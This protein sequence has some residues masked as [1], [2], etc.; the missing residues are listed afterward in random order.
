MLPEA[1]S[2]DACSLV[3]YQDRLAVTVELE[4]RGPKVVKSTFYRSLIRS[5]ERLDYDRVD[6]IFAGREQRRRAVGARRSPPR[7]RAPA[8]LGSAREQQAIALDTAEPEFRFDARG[9]ITHVHA[10]R[11]DRVA[12]AHRAPDDRRQ[13]GGRRRCSRTARCR[14]STA[15]TSGPSPRRSSGSPTSSRRS[16][17]RRRRS[18]E[19]IVADA[20]PPRSP[21]ELSRAVADWV[22][23]T[24]RGRRALTYAR[25]ALA[26]AG[27]LLAAEH[28][29]RR[30]AAA[31]RYCHFTSPIRRYPDIVCHRGLLSAIGAG[32]EPYE[33]SRLEEAGEWTSQRERDAM[34]IERD[35]D[36]VARAFLLERAAASR[37]GDGARVRGRGRLAHRRRR[38]RRVRRR[39]RGAA[40]GPA[41]ARRLVGAQ[42]AGH[43]AA[44]AREGG[45]RDPPR[46][47]GARDASGAIDAPRGRV[48]LYPVELS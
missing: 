23:Q 4:V 25:A 13:R 44:S 18:P 39:L 48:D 11:A 45:E 24:G 43:D 9:H 16:T 30:A 27:V 8:A 17:S 29:P 46:R 1:L 34:V 38:V 40:A 33:R 22:E 6:R 26:Q 12:P 31:P 42:R 47:P 35:A 10:G 28:R 3:P 37:S 21:A 32:E 5:D 20:R 15:C 2:N 41:P 36:D 14:R 19:R 7:A